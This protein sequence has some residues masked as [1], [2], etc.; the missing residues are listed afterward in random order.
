M[1]RSK[2]RLDLQKSLVGFIVGDIAYAVP[3]SHV[4][5]IINPIPLT[6]LPHAPA[7]VAGVA[8]HRGE[9]VVV[10]DLR[11]Q[12]GQP[13]A[14]TD[15]VTRRRAKWILVQTVQGAVGL[16]VDHV[17]DVFGTGGQALQVSPN[18][19]GSEQRGF[20]GVLNHGQRLSYVLDVSR[21]EA[22]AHSLR[23]PPLINRNPE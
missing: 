19:G 20:L 22:L 12:L 6:P 10:V 16:A 15:P 13:P 2:E 3:I 11:R 5:E 1:R 9:V 23:P 4:R 17:T 7:V 14:P 8:D 18:V 21:F